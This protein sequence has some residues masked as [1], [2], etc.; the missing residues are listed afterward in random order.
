MIEW[1]LQNSRNIVFWFILVLIEIPIT[2]LIQIY[3]NLS[4][5]NLLILSVSLFIFFFILDKWFFYILKISTYI[6]DLIKEFKESTPGSYIDSEEFLVSNRLVKPFDK[7]NFSIPSVSPEFMQYQNYLFEVE[8]VKLTAEKTF[9]TDVIENHSQIL[10]CSSG[11]MGKTTSLFQIGY[12]SLEYLEKVFPTDRFYILFFKI[13]IRSIRFR[14]NKNLKLL[15]LPLLFNFNKQ[16][17]KVNQIFPDN[18]SL[19]SC[20]K[21]VKMSKKLYRLKVSFL[22]LF[23]NFIPH[24]DDLN[25]LETKFEEIKQFSSKIICTTS[26]AILQSHK[27]QNALRSKNFA[28]YILDYLDFSDVN[29][30]L[31]H[32]ESNVQRE[33]KVEPLLYEIGIKPFEPWL[34]T[35]LMNLLRHPLYMY[36]Y[37]KISSSSINE[38]IMAMELFE[39][40]FSLLKEEIEEKIG[41]KYF[42]NTEE[43]INNIT[44]WFLNEKFGSFIPISDRFLLYKNQ[45]LEDNIIIRQESSFFWH[46]ELDAYII[47]L[48]VT[49]ELYKKAKEEYM[50]YEPIIFFLE[51]LV[52]RDEWFLLYLPKFLE[53][54]TLSTNSNLL[55]A[56]FQQFIQLNISQKLIDKGRDFEIQQYLFDDL[57]YILSIVHKKY[58]EANIFFDFSEKLGETT[59]HHYNLRINNELNFGNTQKM[60]LYAEK[61]IEIDPYNSS[62]YGTLGVSEMLNRNFVSAIKILS[63]GIGKHPKDRFLAKNLAIAQ[64]FGL[65]YK[66]SLHTIEQFFPDTIIWKNVKQ[67]KKYF[68]LDL[69]YLKAMDFFQIKDVDRSIKILKDVI[70]LGSKEARFRQSL[71]YIYAVKK[72]YTD[73]LNLFEE[74]HSVLNLYYPELYFGWIIVMIESGR[75]DRLSEI[76]DEFESKYPNESRLL[77]LKGRLSEFRNED[78]KAINYYKEVLDQRVVQKEALKRLMNIYYK[79]GRTEEAS[80]ILKQAI[81]KFPKEQYFQYLKTD[82]LKE[83]DRIKQI[84][85]KV[86]EFQN[87]E[88][89]NQDI[90]IENVVNMIDNKI[91]L[92]PESIEALTLLGTGELNSVELSIKILKKKLPNINVNKIERVHD[93]IELVV[94]TFSFNQFLSNLIG[95]KIPEEVQNTI[96]SDLDIFLIASKDKE[97]LLEGLVGSLIFIEKYIF[98]LR[99]LNLITDTFKQLGKDE[100]AERFSKWIKNII[101]N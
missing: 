46:S 65:H 57:A 22:L 68:G 27:V 97:Y 42:I 58:E 94:Q 60:K 32:L 29:N 1:L 92:D 85:S 19:H 13:L 12:N 5:Y 17:T 49:K 59:I 40:Y 67:N 71:A 24:P 34:Q 87:K 30:F 78:D 20:K 3:L 48:I 89:D 86:Q 66:E 73:S 41:Y 16:K 10:L 9:L 90:K 76:L 47:Y 51:T 98:R 74:I 77:F 44:L 15:Y 33:E 69:A 93:L 35:R 62:A 14:K 23:D 45:L 84:K 91:T 31:N 83:R 81:E 72:N 2:T 50:A 6:Y 7:E 25:Q 63:E 43:F 61:I 37:R 55:Q 95:G 75:L 64:N 21:I 88:D 100:L 8:D 82:I 26:L 70:I 4:W 39:K 101:E 38:D 99:I 36:F 79:E 96:M 80:S 28:I 53:L 18:S 11:G 52:E 54:L 56:F